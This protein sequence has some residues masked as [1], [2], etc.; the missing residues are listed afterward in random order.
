[1]RF[2]NLVLAASLLLVCIMLTVQSAKADNIQISDNPGEPTTVIVLPG[3]GGS[4]PITITPTSCAETGAA[5]P[6]N[7]SIKRPGYFMS[8]Y[9]LGGTFN[10]CESTTVC[11]DLQTPVSDNL[12]PSQ[13][14]VLELQLHFSSDLP[15]TPEGSLGVCGVAPFGGCS[16]TN[17]ENGTAVL[18]PGTITW[19]NT[20][21]PGPATITDT[22]SVFSDTA[23]ESAAVT[24]E[25][26]SLIL[27]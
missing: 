4:G 21:V 20:G 24:P 11:V 7:F 9:T 8:G 18:V 27:F 25:P 6:C 3:P 17:I 16:P 14:S 12:D 2:R 10:L 19:T 26:A 23:N 5:Q 15:S 1:M 22:V 13:I